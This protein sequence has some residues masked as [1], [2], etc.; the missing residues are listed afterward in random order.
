MDREMVCGGQT[1]VLIGEARLSMMNCTADESRW[2]RD[3]RRKPA[4]RIANRRR[5]RQRILVIFGVEA[6][7]MP[8]GC[9]LIAE[10]G[11]NPQNAIFRLLAQSIVCLICS[12]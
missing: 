7:V 3:R 11:K 5:K 6:D 10:P 12:P 9:I 1:L 2:C 4:P 8:S